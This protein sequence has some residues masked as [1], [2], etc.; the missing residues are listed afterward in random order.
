M[1]ILVISILVAIVISFASLMITRRKLI[2]ITLA[3][4]V[5]PLAVSIMIIG[6]IMT[7]F[8][9]I[10]ISDSLDRHS[11]P[12]V[13]ASVVSTE[14]IGD[15]AYSPQLNCTYTVED[16]TYSLITD[17]KTPGFGRKKTRRQTS[18]II[19]KDYP[20]GSKVQIRYNPD[21]PEEAFIRTGPYWSD[22]M[23]ISLGVLLTILGL[24]G[25]LGIFIKRFS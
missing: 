2:Q 6:I 18:E 25:I 15:R 11:W 1:M 8:S 14:I 3:K 24:Y 23:K 12:A 16:K 4:W 21:N 10:D 19:L 13:E 17:L 9:A 22:Y 7:I 5:F 20:V